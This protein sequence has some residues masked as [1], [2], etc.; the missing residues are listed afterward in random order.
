MPGIKEIAGSE[1]LPEKESQPQHEQ[2]AVD[3]SI[4]LV[5]T[6]VGNMMKSPFSGQ[7]GA[8]AYEVM[9]TYA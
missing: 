8:L 4:S 9:K 2:T 5:N 3:T 7:R 6:R 1:P